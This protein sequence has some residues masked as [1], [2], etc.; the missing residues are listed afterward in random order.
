MNFRKQLQ[1]ITTSKL[2]F[3]IAVVVVLCYFVLSL[4]CFQILVYI[5]S[6]P[7]LFSHVVHCF[8]MQGMCLLLLNHFV[9]ITSVVN[10]EQAISLIKLCKWISFTLNVWWNDLLRVM[11]K[12]TVSIW[13]LSKRDP[14]ST[15]ETKQLYSLL[16]NMFYSVTPLLFFFEMA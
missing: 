4:A 10:T 2:L 5:L 12:V 15:T 9:L 1:H 14:L 7:L 6:R 13:L 11:Y 3:I 8:F 16:K